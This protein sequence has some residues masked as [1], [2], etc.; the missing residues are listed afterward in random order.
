MS[1]LSNIVGSSFY[2]I[3]VMVGGR[4]VIRSYGRSIGSKFVG[5]I[6][7][8]PVGR[9]FGV[10]CGPGDPA[11]TF[12]AGSTKVRWIGRIV[13]RPYGR[14]IGSGFV[15]AIYEFPGGT[16]YILISPMSE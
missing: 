11:P 6:H 5:A 13:I 12:N 4:I 8:S 10:F 3:A 16:R 15:G 7:E 1:S 2:L 9:Q 14:S